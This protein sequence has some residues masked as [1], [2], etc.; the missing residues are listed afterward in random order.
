MNSEQKK[1][2]VRAINKI[3]KKW[4]DSVEYE[5]YGFLVEWDNKKGNMFYL[6]EKYPEIEKATKEAC[7]FKDVTVTAMYKMAD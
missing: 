3:V 4:E 6:G 7:G 5:P 1:E 2:R